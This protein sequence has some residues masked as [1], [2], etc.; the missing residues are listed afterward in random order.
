[1]K[2]KL[3]QDVIPGS[4]LLKINSFATVFARILLR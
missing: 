2:D 4:I 3:Q 1:M